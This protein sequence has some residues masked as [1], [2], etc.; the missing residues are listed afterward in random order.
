MGPGRP[1][2]LD[3]VRLVT[4]N[5]WK[6]EGDYPRRLELM[7]EGL[8]SLDPD[9]LLLQEVFIGGGWDSAGWLANRLGLHACTVPARVKVRA[10]QG[11]RQLCASGM[12][13]LTRGPT[14]AR[15]H[16][17]PSD[18]RDGERVAMSVDS[19]GGEIRILN[20]H[21]THLAG[22]QGDDLRARQLAE[23]L[24]WAA[25]DP[26]DRLIVG[27]DLNAQASAPCLAELW[28]GSPPPPEIGSTLHGTGPAIDH[29][30]MI[31][32]GLPQARRVLTHP[33]ANGVLPSD[34]CGLLVD[35]ADG[36]DWT[37]HPP[38]E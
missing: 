13:I 34:H 18:P 15:R 12:A 21:L 30:I 23:A 20:L 22:P 3:E 37:D 31:G 2:G 7:A 28:G 35:W 33:D 5:T 4:L 19:P 32:G 24:T 10:H 26:R 1:G 38:G 17:L 14:T 25:N 11:R 6:N 8:A 36:P 27:G 9:V 29:L 16:H